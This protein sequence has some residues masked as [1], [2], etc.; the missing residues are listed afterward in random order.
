[1]RGEKI[2]EDQRPIRYGNGSPGVPGGE[3][4]KSEDGKGSSCRCFVLRAG[5][6]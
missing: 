2:N 5:V 6:Q 3:I 1:M 4:G